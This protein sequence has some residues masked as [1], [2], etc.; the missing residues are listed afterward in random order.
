MSNASTG[1]LKVFP[2]R[3]RIPIV[4]RLKTY[5]GES[6]RPFQRFYPWEVSAKTDVDVLKTS[7]KTDGV[8]SKTA[9]PID[10]SS[11]NTDTVGMR[12]H[13]KS[14]SGRTIKIPCRLSL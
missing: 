4:A 1:L 14:R 13:P 8:V 7:R 9:R 5:K 3:D 2:G 10:P 11:E 6:I 12:H